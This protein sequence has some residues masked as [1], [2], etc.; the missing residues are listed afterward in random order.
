MPT[1]LVIGNKNYSSWSL[2]AWLPLRHLEI[3]FEEERIALF[4]PGYKDC[5]LA[6]S[7]AGKVPVLID[8]DT[9]VWDSLAIGEYLADKFPERGL[10][11]AGRAPTPPY[12]S[13]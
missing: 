10:R 11:P 2:R 7:S 4:A 6:R 3:P 5:I 13:G 8:G 9:T 12:P 1:T